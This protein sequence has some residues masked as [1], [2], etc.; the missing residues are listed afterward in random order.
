MTLYMLPPIRIQSFTAA[1]CQINAS[2]G[3]LAMHAATIAIHKGASTDRL[4][5]V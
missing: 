2:R 5:T 1:T 4:V 3:K